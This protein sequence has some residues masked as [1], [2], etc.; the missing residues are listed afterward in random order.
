MSAPPAGAEPPATAPHRLAVVIPALNEARTIGGVVTDAR[1]LATVIVVDDGSSDE[2]AREAEAAGAEVVRHAQNRGYDG[3]L[4]SGFGRA[5]SLP[6]EWAVNVDADAQHDLSTLEHFGREL[7]RGA[8]LVVGIRDRKQRLGERVFAWYTRVRWGI[9]DPFCGMKGYRL[10]LWRELGPF[11]SYSSV[12]TELRLY[13]AAAGKRITQVPVAT[14]V[15]VGSPRF[16]ATFS[17]N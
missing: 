10:D 4:N 13:A 16:G 14:R 2:T 5:G 15:R 9:E 11:A 1:R 3:A 8:D 12:G 7:G 6:C 17:A